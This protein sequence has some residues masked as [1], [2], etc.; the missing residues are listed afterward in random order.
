MHNVQVCYICILVPCCCAA[1]INSSFTSGI[2]P[3]AIPPPSPL[4]MIGPGVWDWIKKVCFF[5]KMEFCSVAHAGVQWYDLS[6]WQAHL[7]GPS[8]SPCLSLLS[9]WDYR[10]LPPRLP[11]F[12]ICSSIGV[13]PCWPGWPQTPDLRRFT[14]LSLPKFWDYGCESLYLDLMGYF[15]A[16]FD[17]QN[18]SIYGV[19]FIL[20][21][22]FFFGLNY[23]NN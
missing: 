13:S 21:I 10:P 3:N 7:L 15:T 18:I 22:L 19:L 11:N 17:K 1:P 5:F 9:S 23:N 8:N 12:C 16:D 20:L 14:R 2:T 6:S 4:P